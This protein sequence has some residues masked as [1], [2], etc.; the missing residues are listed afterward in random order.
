MPGP[1]WF[2]AEP[3]GGAGDWQRQ[4]LPAMQSQV[5]VSE[6][7]GPLPFDEAIL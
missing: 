3:V 5:G 2:M 4:V 1:A 6:N 7:R